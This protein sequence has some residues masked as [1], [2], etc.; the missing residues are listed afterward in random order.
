M[1]SCA[2]LWQLNC[3]LRLSQRHYGFQVHD[4]LCPNL[5]LIPI[6]QF[7]KRQ[8]HL[9]IYNRNTGNSWQLNIP[10]NLLCWCNVLR[11]IRCLCDVT[12][13]LW[14][15]IHTGLRVYIH[16]LVLDPV[17]TVPDLG[18]VWNSSFFACLHANLSC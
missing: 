12:L 13:S 9:Y 11:W 5:Y 1:A 18:P 15:Y 16:T 8:M 14:V 10:L 7:I 17:Y 6:W 3:R 4:G 2:S